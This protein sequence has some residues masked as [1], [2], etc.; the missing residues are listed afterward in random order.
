M[1]TPS[2]TEFDAIPVS[3]L[4]IDGR[5]QRQV[6]DHR[7]GKMVE[8]WKP[9]L[10]GTL[11][12]SKRPN[13]TYAVFDGQHRLSAIKALSLKK[14]PCI[15]HKGLTVQDEADLFVRLQRDRRTATPVERFKAQVFSGDKFATD[16]SDIITRCGFKVGTNPGDLRAVTS[17]ERVARGYGLE[18]LELTLGTIR[19]I[20]FGDDYALDAVI[21][22]GLA[23][24]LHD[25]S[26]RWEDRHANRLRLQ[27]PIDIKRRAQAGGGNFGGSASTVVAAQIRKAAG[28]TGRRRKQKEPT[29]E[30]VSA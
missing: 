25:Y 1:T 26:D 13:G 16:I 24:V 3:K 7:V 10:V 28:L 30:L 2:T 15:V 22:G 17:A 18:V 21:I 5:Y 29:L 27:A 23:M 14:A 8:N 11:E 4:V 12:V 20:W 6:N 9:S 19:D